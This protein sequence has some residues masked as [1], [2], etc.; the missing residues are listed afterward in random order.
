MNRG[1]TGVLG[2]VGGRRRRRGVEWRGRRGD[3]SGEEWAA[4]VDLANLRAKVEGANGLIGH[5]ALVIAITAAAGG[6]AR[7]R[8]GT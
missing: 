6:Q 1:V 8:I 4:L 3:G 2:V 7:I 5:C